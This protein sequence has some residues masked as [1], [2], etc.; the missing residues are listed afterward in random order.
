M[1]EESGCVCV[2]VGG[3]GSISVMLIRS[4]HATDRNTMS[5]L[6]IGCI[7]LILNERKSIFDL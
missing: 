6:H 5:G 4:G 3:G 7:H 2:C 1:P